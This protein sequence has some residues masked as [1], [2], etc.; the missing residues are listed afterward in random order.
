MTSSESSFSRLDF[1]KLALGKVLEA[2]P[3]PGQSEVKQPRPFLRPPGAVNEALFLGLCTRCDACT[4][5]CPHETVS[6]LYGFGFPN[7]GTPVLKDLSANSCLMCEDTPCITACPT[8][9]LS[10]IQSIR[11]IA[12]GMAVIDRLTCSAFRGSKC[13]TCY[14]VCPLKD[15]A[16]E[17]KE[18]L[19]F[20]I[21][22]GCT[23]CGICTAHCP[24][25][26]DAISILPR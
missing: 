21:A 3:I 17:L 2:V 6:V 5:M 19:P 18:G 24:E 13:T 20:V 25:K 11:E 15:E 22:D 16:I 23:G 12:I 7:D 26:P 14:D 10:P 8:G 9:A 4:A 1:L